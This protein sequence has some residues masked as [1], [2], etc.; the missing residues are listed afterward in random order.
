MEPRQRAFLDALRNDPAPGQDSDLLETPFEELK[1]VVLARLEAAERPK[2]GGAVSGAAAGRAKRVYVVC[3]ARDSEN[4]RPLQKHLFDLG[5]EVL[6]PVFE[7]DEAGLRKYHETQ[8]SE[9]D[10]LIIYY[11]AGSELWLNEKLSEL[12]RLAA[13]RKA[14]LRSAAICIVPPITPAKQNVLT[15]DAL[16]ITMPGGFTPDAL[17]AFT[18]ALQDPET[19]P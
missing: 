17:R 13:G 6:P 15:H 19:P 9:C 18:T 12:R 1:N 4:V 7:G 14:P 2:A 16:T 3:D 5:F 8:L 10:G 11:G